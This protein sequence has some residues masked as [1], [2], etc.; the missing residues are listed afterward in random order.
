MQDW[1]YIVTGCMELTL[2]LS[3]NK[4]P[5]MPQLAK[6]WTQNLD[7]LLGL[8]LMVAFGGVHG[9]VYGQTGGGSMPKPDAHGRRRLSQQQLPSGRPL[10]ATIAVVDISHNITAGREFGD[11]YRP[12]A[13]GTY[14]LMATMPG[15]HPSSATVQVPESGQG[16]V[17]DFLLKPDGSQQAPPPDDSTVPKAGGTYS[18]Q[19]TS[20]SQP[21]DDGLAADGIVHGALQF[22]WSNAPYLLTALLLL[23]STTYGSYMLVIK[24]Q[25][26]A[27]QEELIELI[28]K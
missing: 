26:Y 10:A 22:S 12:L 4:G 16:V 3:D 25:K 8:P 5:P 17:H 6:M 14:T 13:P 7:A 23:C 11:Y 15:Y 19:D 1:N 18:P 28:S 2:E 27:S 20:R 24:A 9:K 21:R